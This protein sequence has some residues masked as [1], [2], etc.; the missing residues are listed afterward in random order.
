EFQAVQAAFQAWQNVPYATVS[1]KYMGT[2]P[3]STVGHD[4]LNVVTFADTN[5]P[6]GSGTVSATFSFFSVDATGT[7]TFQEFD[8]A[9]NPAIPFSTSAEPSKYDV[10]SVVTHEVGHFLGFEHS[11]LLSAVMTPNST[12][13]QLDQRTLTFDDMSG[14]AFL[15]TNNSTTAGF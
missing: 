1:F 10:Q 15:Y 12:P 4:G 2:T 11:P 3:V 14:L 5:V 13:G 9:L 8:I 7:L 6:L